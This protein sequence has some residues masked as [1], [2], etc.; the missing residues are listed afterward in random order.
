MGFMVGEKINFNSKNIKK[1]TQKMERDRLP[2]MI[3]WMIKEKKQGL[4]FLNITIKMQQK[5]LKS[6]LLNLKTDRLIDKLSAKKII[7]ILSAY[8][9]L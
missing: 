2:D 5:Q 1:S 7:A 6:T 4:Y 9:R 3:F 8:F